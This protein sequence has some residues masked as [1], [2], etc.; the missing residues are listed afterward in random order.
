MADRYVGM[1]TRCRRRCIRG[2]RGGARPLWQLCR[3]GASGSSGRPHRHAFRQVDICHW[4][5]CSAA[6]GPM[7]GLLQALRAK[8]ACTLPMFVCWCRQHTT[9]AHAMAKAEAHT[10]HAGKAGC[11]RARRTGICM[12]YAYLQHTKVGMHAAGACCSP[13]VFRNAAGDDARAQRVQRVFARLHALHA[14]S[15]HRGVCDCMC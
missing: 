3:P 12:Q 7:H 8:P 15:R 1:P 11:L 10:Q 13:L 14:F 2:G 6:M 4:L 5:R 9:H